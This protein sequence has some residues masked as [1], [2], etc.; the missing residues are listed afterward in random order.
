MLANRHSINKS[1]L[2]KNPSKVK[3]GNHPKELNHNAH[4]GK[5][6]ARQFLIHNCLLHNISKKKNDCSILEKVTLEIITIS[7]RISTNLN[8]NSSR[9]KV[10]HFCFTIVI[11]MI[12]NNNYS[13]FLHLTLQN[14]TKREED[15]S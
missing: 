1:S 14:R 11:L 6:L 15:N 7:Y 8:C 4:Q 3:D 12:R 2:D 13:R 5:H 9:S 10:L